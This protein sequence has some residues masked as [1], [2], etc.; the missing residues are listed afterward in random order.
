MTCC[1]IVT[2]AIEFCCVFSVA[3]D[4]PTLKWLIPNRRW[5]RPPN[6]LEIASESSADAPTPGFCPVAVRAALSS[7]VW[8]RAS[9]SMMSL[10]GNGGSDRYA[11]VRRLAGPVKSRVT[12]YWRIVVVASTFNTGSRRNG[13][14]KLMSP[15]AMVY[16]LPRK[17]ISPLNK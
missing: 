11:S 13:L 17:L 14:A 3:T 4:G 5:M 1:S 10:E 12:S 16:W 7:P 2:L 15:R 8:P 9:S 6:W